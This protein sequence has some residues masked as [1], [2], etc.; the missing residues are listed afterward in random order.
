MMLKR[1]ICVEYKY[2]KLFNCEL[3]LIYCCY[4]VWNNNE[5]HL[6]VEVKSNMAASFKS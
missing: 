1:I 5:Q 6:H 4:L 2:L 3:K